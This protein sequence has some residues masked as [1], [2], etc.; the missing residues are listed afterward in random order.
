MEERSVWKTD[1]ENDDITATIRRLNTISKEN[2][3]DIETLIKKLQILDEIWQSAQTG[4]NNFNAAR[5]TWELHPQYDTD[6]KYDMIDRLGQDVWNLEYECK[7]VG[8]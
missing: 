7:M 6:F 2:I 1:I 5:Y 3:G 4:Q 8:E